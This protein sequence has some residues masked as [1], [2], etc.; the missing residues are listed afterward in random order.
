MEA[1][2]RRERAAESLET[3]MRQEERVDG[4]LGRAPPGLEDNLERR[5]QEL[6]HRETPERESLELEEK[7]EESLP[8]QEDGVKEGPSA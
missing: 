6:E 2:A 1:A 4:S 8:R 3:M 5:P 7:G